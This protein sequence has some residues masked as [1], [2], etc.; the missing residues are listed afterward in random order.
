MW[1]VVGLIFSHVTMQFVLG[2][3][4]SQN[5]AAVDLGTLVF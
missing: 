1:N 5:I 3:N 4:E 2:I